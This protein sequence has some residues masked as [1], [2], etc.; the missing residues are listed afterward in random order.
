M[1]THIHTLTVM[2]GCHRLLTKASNTLNSSA[3]CLQLNVT[4][5]TWKQQLLN[6]PCLKVHQTVWTAENT[7]TVWFTAF[8]AL[9]A[10]QLL[11]L[12]LTDK[13]KGT[14]LKN[15]SVT[16]QGEA[17]GSPSVP[18]GHYCCTHNMNHLLNQN[19][20]QCSGNTNLL[21][22]QCSTS[23]RAGLIWLMQHNSWFCPQTQKERL[24]LSSNKAWN[25]FLETT[26]SWSKHSSTWHRIK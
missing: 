16:V 19:R 5:S 8:V 14:A 2:M 6:P 23:L 1:H 25:I 18:C 24:T 11:D 12:L 10:V 13:Q 15:I 21:P 3:L 22:Q 17:D 26:C 4:M 7:R 20:G 9:S